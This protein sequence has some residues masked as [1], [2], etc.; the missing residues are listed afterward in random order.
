ME[1]NVLIDITLQGILIILYGIIG[2]KAFHIGKKIKWNT[3]L[4]DRRRN[5]L[6]MVSGI[7]ILFIISS[8]LLV[9]TI[10]DIYIYFSFNLSMA[11]IYKH[12]YETIDG[13]NDDR[14]TNP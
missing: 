5:S 14:T 12:F 6:Y 3:W 2:Y 10:Q 8:V 11:F 9:T 7:S 13:D 1:N 4:D